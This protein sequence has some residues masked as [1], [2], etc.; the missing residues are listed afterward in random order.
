M[1]ISFIQ[2]PELFSTFEPLLVSRPIEPV[3]SIFIRSKR[4]PNGNM[5]DVESW[6][7]RE[8]ESSKAYQAFL[9]YRELGAERSIREAFRQYNRNAEKVHKREEVWW[10]WSSKYKW[11]ARAE[12]WDTYINST[13]DKKLLKGI[14]EMRARHIE[15]AIKLQDK[16]I[17]RLDALEP[18]EIEPKHIPKYIET[19]VRIERMARGQVTEVV[20][21]GLSELPNESQISA[22]IALL[23][24]VPGAK[25]RIQELLSNWEED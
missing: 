14:S 24:G 25:E 9:T 22:I 10:R 18:E 11:V 8:G 17:D 12:A 1:V 2:A 16:V 20:Q 6:K 21:R 15:R 19:A 13:L 4:H 7:R 3:I 5:P 23:D